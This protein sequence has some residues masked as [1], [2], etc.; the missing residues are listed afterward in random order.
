[1]LAWYGI[2]PTWQLLWLPLFVALA[3][4]QAS[5]LGLWLG[6]INV[7]FRDV[8]YALPFAL[9]IWMYASPI[10][11][12]LSI[13]P[14]AWRTLYSLNPMV[15]VIEGFRWALI[16]GPRPSLAILALS[17]VLPLVLLM[18]GVLFFRKKERSFADV[19]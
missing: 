13:V 15:G 12:P 18:G 6:P 8:M 4:I 17:V 9:Q 5:A 3:L 10:I 11:Y 1:M 19:I 16:G 7:R 14:E 2:P